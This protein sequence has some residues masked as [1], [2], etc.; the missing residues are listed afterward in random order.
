M[1]LGERG[2]KTFKQIAE[3]SEDDLA[4]FDRELNLKGRAVRDS[5]V[6]QAKGLA[7]DL[8]PVLPD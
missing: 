5:W 1:A 4:Y 7:T 3:W 6:E 2:I 8:T